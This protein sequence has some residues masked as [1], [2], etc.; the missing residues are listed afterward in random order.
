MSLCCQFVL[1]RLQDTR[2]V[3]RVLSVQM[4]P[5]RRGVASVHFPLVTRRGYVGPG[6]LTTLAQRKPLSFISATAGLARG[7]SL[8]RSR[9]MIC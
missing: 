1:V 2:H 9:M 7:L 8:L 5:V 6:V 4:L 3:P